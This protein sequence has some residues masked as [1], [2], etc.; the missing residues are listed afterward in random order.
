MSFWLNK[1]KEKYV[2]LLVNVIGNHAD[3]DNM[4]GGTYIL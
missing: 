2:N 3:D 1:N 4:L